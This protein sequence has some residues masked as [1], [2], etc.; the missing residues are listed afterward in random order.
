M[1]LTS[2]QPLRGRRIVLTRAARGKSALTTELENLGA[3]VLELPLIAVDF[4][5]EKEQA[6]PVFAEMGQY[7]WLIFTS[8][9][10]VDGFFQF[11]LERFSDI[12]ALGLA[13]LAVVGESTARAVRQYHLA[14][15][16]QPAV[17]TAEDLADALGE[18][19][20][21]DNLR[22]LVVQGSRNRPELVNRLTAARAIVDTLGVYKTQTAD[23]TGHAGAAQFRAEG[24]DA[25]VFASS[26]AVTAFGENATH[27]QLS[28]DAKVPALASFGPETTAT[29]RQAGI[30]L[31]VQAETPSIS[32][33][34]EALVGHFSK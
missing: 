24:A 11:F 20:S 17:A 19:M 3:E 25:L 1:I 23:L 8:R 5:L 33:M 28:E 29:M 4:A 22:V 27:L 16:L 15:D 26:S 12:R 13:R 14:V 2:E 21:L 32:A 7:E 10:G 34:V 31:T 9:N 30:P 6:D 18:E